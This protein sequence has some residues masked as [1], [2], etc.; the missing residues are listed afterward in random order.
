[1]TGLFIGNNVVSA[2]AM[3]SQNVLLS[4]KKKKNLKLPTSKAFLQ[5]V[6]K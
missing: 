5:E 1:M 6:T 3:F 4:P 2:K